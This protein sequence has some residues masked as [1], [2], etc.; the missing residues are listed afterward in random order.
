M[1]SNS[2]SRKTMKA[3]RVLPSVP[4]ESPRLKSVHFNS[5]TIETSIGGTQSVGKIKQDVLL[6]FG[7][8]I[9]APSK[10]GISSQTTSQTRTFQPNHNHS[11]KENKNVQN[12]AGS[13]AA[14][15]IP[16]P[17]LVSDSEETSKNSKTSKENRKTNS[18]ADSASSSTTSSVSVAAMSSNYETTVSIN[19]ARSKGASNSLSVKNT[20]FDQIRK[21]VTPSTKK[22]NKVNQLD[23]SKV[24]SDSS[25]I[26][27]T[28]LNLSNDELCS[29]ES[30]SEEK[31]VKESIGYDSRSS[32]SSNTASLS[33]LETENVEEDKSC[34][35]SQQIRRT[36]MDRI[37][38]VCQNPFRTPD[39]RQ[40]RRHTLES[41]VFSTPDCYHDVTL[42]TPRRL[43]PSIQDDSVDDGIDDPD[44]SSTCSIMVA[45]RVRPF[46]QR[47]LSDANTHCVV[48]MKGNETT[49]TS[50]NGAVH[51]FAYDFSF[52]SHDD[53][54]DD[55]C[56]Q[57]DVYK[58]LAQP[59]LG[60][61]FE[62]YNTCLFAYGQ[63]GSGKSYCIMGH[64]P[65]T[66]IIPRF[67]EELF[68]KA[69]MLASKKQ[70][71]VNVEISFF[72]IYNEK[73]HDLLAANKDK[74]QKKATLKVREHPVLGPYV[75]ALSTYV[76]NSFEDVEVW[77]TL[78]NKNRATAA[79]GMN[80]KSSRSHSVF[81]IVLTQTKTETV[82]GQGHDHSVNSKI[83]L[84]D[85]AGSERQSQANTSGDRLRE[86]ANINKSLLTLGKVISLLAERSNL[87][88]KRK[89]FI[90]YRDSVL[91]WLLKESL[92]GNSKTVMIATISPSNQHLE[93]TLSTLRY[94]HQ[95]RSIVN[96]VH[97]NE[98]PKAKIIR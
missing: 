9:S 37:E 87:N 5:E 78:G 88:K 21:N 16:Q 27:V 11:V 73:I 65:E 55:F 93:E 31:Q 64:D 7:T 72:E 69:D 70:V 51:R 76:V 98:D 80:D 40:A 63:T 66:G 60:K 61:A 14:G 82:E 19:N 22:V 20:A 86:G 13:T 46:V 56:S 4:P 92:G 59:L 29:T 43:L 15:A 10:T 90:P 45:V 8:P 6:H 34:T 33:A 39:R 41:K 48:S 17:E 28:P 96:R 83:N 23:M 1:A 49:I 79:T 53:K 94:A 77:I 2:S 25:E 84:V 97:I 47:E 81:S 26:K 44:E 71:K 50:D 58:R 36:T 95:A 68:L 38:A 52:W 12:P 42:G 89:V 57:E 74:G 30:E 85:L 3:K 35:S 75:E 67:C 62:G 32:R 54:S 91:T 18:E 24:I